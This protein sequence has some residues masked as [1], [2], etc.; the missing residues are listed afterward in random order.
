VIDFIER[1][2]RVWICDINQ[3]VLAEAASAL[4]GVRASYAPNRYLAAKTRVLSDLLPGKFGDQPA[5][6]DFARAAGVGDS[7]RFPSAIAVSGG[8]LYRCQ[9]SVPG[10]ALS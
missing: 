8:F 3:E 5:W 7:A 6:D 9:L 4:Q 2:T 1:G 10:P